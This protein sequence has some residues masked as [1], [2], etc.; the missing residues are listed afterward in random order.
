MTMQLLVRLIMNA[1]MNGLLLG[2]LLTGSAHGSTPPSTDS[3]Q[4]KTQQ[5]QRSGVLPA[6]I[7]LRRDGTAN[8]TQSE[9]TGFA[10][11]GALLVVV[12]GGFAIFRFRAGSLP[13]WK[14]VL[15]IGPS[16]ATQLERL[17]SVRLTPST[18]VHVVRWNGRQ[19]LIGASES[20]LVN[21]DSTAVSA[22]M[23][24]EQE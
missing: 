18:S 15:R 2:G 3:G 4:V 11:V 20:R 16:E 8:Q 10:V 14:E 23:S 13:A 1:G 6:E 9:W 12:A 22:K 19:Y 5:L 7:P 21:L 17:A 24:A